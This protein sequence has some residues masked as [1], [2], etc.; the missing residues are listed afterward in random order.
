MKVFGK[1]VLAFC[2]LMYISSAFAADTLK[3]HLTY[4]H[5]LDNE[6]R[7]QGFTTIS[8]KFYT[9]EMQL[10]REIKYNDQTG[11]IA[12]YTYYFYTGGKLFTEECY[13]AKDSL[14]YILKHGYDAAGRETEIVRLEP[15][16]GGMAATGKTVTT[17][18]KAGRIHQQKIYFGGKQGSTKSY[19]YTS[20]GNLMSE[21]S[22]FKAV[23][24]QNLKAEKRSYS[25]GADRKVEKVTVTGQ[26]I[27]GK[28]FQHS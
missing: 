20:D 11:Q 21:N 4:K 17:Y 7:T 19:A 14:M 2:L 26:D 27:S 22:K 10:F 6:G 8:Q 16:S 3:I 24:K 18:D 5:R 28:S 1:V 15:R 23:S 13:S 9:P 12:D 25:Y